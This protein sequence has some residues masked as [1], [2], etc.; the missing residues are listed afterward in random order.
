MN[1]L[2]IYISIPFCRAKCTY[3]NFA[4]GVSSVSAHEQYVAR[5][6]SEIRTLRQPLGEALIPEQVDS[7]YLGGGTPSVLSPALMGQL[8]HTLRQEFAVTPEAEITLECAPGQLDDPALAAMLAL[9]VNRISFGVQSLVDREAT[10][11]GRFHTRAVVLQDL[12]RVRSAGLRNLSID[13]IAGMPHQTAA[14]WQESLEVLVATGVEHASIY[15]LEIDE[16]SRLGR[17]LL[18]GG[19]RYHA[20]TVPS[21]ELTADLYESAI[22]FLE[23][24]GLRQYEIS[25][26]ARAGRQSRHNLKYWRRQPY[27]GFGLDAHSMLRTPQGSALRFSNTAVLAEY[28]RGPETAEEVRRLSPAEELEEAWFLGLRLREGV[29]WQALAAEFGRGPVEIFLPVVRELCNLD[30]L[31]DEA[32]LVR[33]TSRGVLFSNEVFARFLG[34]KEE[35][36]IQ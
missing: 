28:L 20:G 25:N 12:E 36:Q 18:A 8:A 9:G 19:I 5:L 23:Q 24:N 3:C 6:C 1:S 13:L 2:G 35:F 14:S 34:V 7:I 15:M 22:P 26:F 33:L 17:E 32:G 4:S 21:E 27:L 31:T 29:A 30:L 16:D 11:T 10:A